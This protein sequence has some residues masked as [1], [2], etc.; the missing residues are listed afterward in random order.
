MGW[1]GTKAASVSASA[2]A[3]DPLP[4]LGGE[5]LTGRQLECGGP[6][7][8]PVAI[9]VGGPPD[10]PFRVGAV[11]QGDCLP[12]LDHPLPEHPDVP[13]VAAV[14]LHPAEQV[15]PLPAVGDLVAGAARLADLDDG[16]PHLVNVAQADAA[17]IL[18]AAGDVLAE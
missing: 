18:S 4:L 14:L 17:L 7:A 12:G 9:S 5:G 10:G 6:V 13:A 1:P 3:E 16:L 8:A 2:A 11:G 15:R